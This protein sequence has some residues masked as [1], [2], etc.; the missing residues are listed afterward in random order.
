MIHSG[1]LYSEKKLTEIFWK[2]S[3]LHD[4]VYLRLDLVLK[5]LVNRKDNKLDKSLLL[6][7]H[8]NSTLFLIYR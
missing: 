1:T 4:E 2:F 6:H 7:N 3:I 5:L 8:L